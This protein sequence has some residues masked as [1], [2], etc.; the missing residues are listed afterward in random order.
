MAELSSVP[1]TH[2]RQLLVTAFDNNE[3]DLLCVDL[4]GDSEVV[5]GGKDDK[6][7]RAA[8][9]I[10]YFDNRGRTLDVLTWCYQQRENLHAELDQ[11]RQQILI[12][13]SVTDDD[14]TATPE[15]ASAPVPIRFWVKQLP[16]V[17][18]EDANKLFNNALGSWQA[19]VDTPIRKAD[20]EAK[21][22]VLI[23]T[24]PETAADAHMGPPTS[25]T[26]PLII[27]FGST[28]VWTSHTFEAASCRMLG[29]ILGLTYTE[30]PGQMMTEHVELESLPL[31]PQAEDIK[32]A[33]QIWGE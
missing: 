29:H 8:K 31:T 16:E 30:L 4:A 28:I 17:P 10:Q 24:S 6:V 23:I 15:T 27:R 5:P 18:G 26:S 1:Q 2:L 3:L 12:A 20:L 9:I 22:N 7:T 19:V 21:A 25:G 13:E 14:R 32:R 33:R 11:L